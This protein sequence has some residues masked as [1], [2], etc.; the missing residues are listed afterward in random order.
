MLALSERF[1]AALLVEGY[2]PR[3]IGAWRYKLRPF[4]A[5]CHERGVDRPQDV[6]RDLLERFKAWQHAWRDEDGKGLAVLSQVGRLIVIRAFFKWLA[7][8]N[9]LLFN[10][11]S[12]VDYP[13]VG[14]RLPKVVFTPSEV[15]QVLA[16]PDLETP[17]GL[18]DRA[19]LETFYSTGLR[20]MEVANLDLTDLDEGRG[21]LLVRQGK[22]AKDRVVPIGERAVA[23]VTKYLADGRPLLVPAPHLRGAVREQ[24][25]GEADGERVHQDGEP[26]RAGGGPREE[27]LVPRLQALR[28]DGHAGERGGHPVHPGD[29]R[30]REAHEHAGLHQGQH[31]EAQSRAHR[32]A[33]GGDAGG[34]TGGRQGTRRGWVER[35]ARAAPG[36]GKQYDAGRMRALKAHVRGGR[37]VVDEPANLP[38]GTEVE[39]TL[40]E[41]DEFSP[42]E[43]ARL[44]QALEEADQEI[45]R[46]EFVDGDEFIARLRARS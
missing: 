31:H 15:E 39:L 12:E 26:L 16:Q 11:A 1:L 19:I 29:A 28:R 2:S 8:N 7:K 38:E 20:R 41:D 27:R 25:R 37:F 40:I 6:T 35:P 18:R 5:W 43:R 42:E 4:L 30:A 10:P 34:E 36:Q 24:D 14:F 22:G 45:E 9:V 23:W 46:G 21:T 44:E 17:L 33:S 3:T 13:K 32:D